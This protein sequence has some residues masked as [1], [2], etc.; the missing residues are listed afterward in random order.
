MDGRRKISMITASKNV[1]VF[2]YL[3][4]KMVNVL[5][6]SPWLNG[7]NPLKMNVSLILTKTLF[8][9]ISLPKLFSQTMEMVEYTA[10]EFL[11]S[12]LVA[13]KVIS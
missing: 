7:K 11:G 5:E 10:R 8:Y 4:Y 12:V 6:D 2:L 3:R 9:S 1:P 13:V